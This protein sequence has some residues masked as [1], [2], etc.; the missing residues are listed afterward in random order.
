MAPHMSVKRSVGFTE[1]E[2]HV[3]RDSPPFL[4]GL[5]RPLF[6]LSI[7]LCVAENKKMPDN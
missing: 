1:S 2:I 4:A 7:N 5:H 3:L 6:K